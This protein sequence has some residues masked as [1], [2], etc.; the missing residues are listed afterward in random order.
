[1][2]A[3]HA[4]E[5]VAELRRLIRHHNRRYYVDQEPEISDREFDVLMTE[6]E[7]LERA[8]PELDDPQ[9]P[10]HRV[11]GEPLVGFTAVRHHAPM[12]SLQNTYSEEEVREF[13]AR[14]HRWLDAAQ[15]LD[16]VVELKIDGVAISLHY[17]GGVFRRGVTRGDG[18]QGDDVTA[19]L[20]TVRS[21]PLVLD[22]GAAQ[23]A[24]LEVR[25]EV[26]FPRASFDALNAARRTAGEKLFANPRNAAAG[27]LKLLDPQQVAARPL[28]LFVYQLVDAP[29]LGLET[30]T[31]ALAR[32]RELGL[33]VNPHA[34]RVSGIDAALELFRAWDLRRHTLAYD[35]D[36]M[37][38]KVDRLAWQAQLGSTSK[39]PRWGIAYKF[40]TIEAVTLVRAIRVQ[41]GRTGSV[42][43]VAELEPVELRGT[44]VKRAT[45][46]NA[47]EIIRL[48]VRLGDT[49]TLAK[50]GEI[51]PKVTGVLRA[52]RTGAEVPFTFPTHCPVCGDPLEREAGQ[53]VIRCVNEHCPAQ[54]KRSIL[55]FASRAGMD[56]KG[57]GAAVADQLVDRG[58]VHNVADLFTLRLD[59]LAALDAMANPAARRQPSHKA[60][61][62]GAE[63]A[64]LI[65]D[66]LQAARQRPLARLLFAL[67]IRHV[68][69]HAARLLAQ[70]HPS[71]AA[72]GQA[73]EEQLAAIP[74][75][76]PV[77]AASVCRYFARPETQQLLARLEQAGVSTAETAPAAA[78]ASLAGLTFV[79]TGT[80]AG[81]TR[82]EAQH[83]IE[84]HGGR[85]AASV[86]GKTNYVVAGS[87]PG[88][89][90]ARARELGINVLDEAGLRALLAQAAQADA[91][92]S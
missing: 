31:A 52:R 24:E 58:R 42:T 6:L 86:S 2:H 30:H 61:V 85:V 69:S 14:T 47:D 71:L 84:S 89:K 76:G 75:I 3:K 66:Q 80:L 77:I 78:A 44:I 20:R 15:D 65:L 54:L 18:M 5:R 26:Y 38:L 11:G 7:A 45:L 70:A 17:A 40:E 25:G 4:A 55:H 27:T 88:A 48:D 19:N 87:D 49:V 41:V 8:H 39:A 32:L 68:G 16:Y 82:T 91:N 51:I 63:R 90:L 22:A 12:L 9:S 59:E 73:E 62:L 37:V 34:C 79:L 72:L 74:E 83:A 67:G 46:H 29:R 92:S 64:Q 1:M 28:A 60:P 35:I 36:G 57:L 56:I 43:P 50:G 13:D 23:A 81:L 10:T 21:L 53:V 33:P